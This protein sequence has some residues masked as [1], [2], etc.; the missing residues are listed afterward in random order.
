[1]DADAKKNHLGPTAS[2]TRDFWRRKPLDMEQPPVEPGNTQYLMELR[3]AARMRPCRRTTSA[4]R[5]EKR[6]SRGKGIEST[7]SLE[8]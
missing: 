2:S 7:L 1:V 5:E 6:R 8:T 4:A 3:H